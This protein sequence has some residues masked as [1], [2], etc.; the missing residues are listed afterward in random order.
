MCVLV[1][2]YFGPHFY[3]N[4]TDLNLF[5]LVSVVYCKIVYFG[6]AAAGSSNIEEQFCQ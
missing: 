6:I 2:F 4:F 5:S 1:D 3:V